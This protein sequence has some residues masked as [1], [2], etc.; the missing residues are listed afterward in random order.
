MPTVEKEMKHPPQFVEKL[1]NMGIP[2]GTPVRLECRVVGMPP[3]LIFW[4]KDNDTI[5]RSKDRIR[6]VLSL[7]L[8]LLQ[9]HPLKNYTFEHL[10]KNWEEFSID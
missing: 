8:Y 2:E 6:L 10:N 3:P 7:L 4:K 9:Y 1:Q 5:P